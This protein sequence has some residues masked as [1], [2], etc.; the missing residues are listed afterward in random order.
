MKAIKKRTI[1]LSDPG[2]VEFIGQQYL[3]KP[4]LQMFTYNKDSYAED[5][6]FSIDKYRGEMPAGQVSWMNVHGIHDTAL[7][8]KVCGIAGIP[9]FIVQDIL[10]TN[11]RPKFQDLDDYVFITVKS[12]LPSSDQNLEIEQISFLLGR[13]MLISFQEK[14]GDHFEHVRTRI[15]EGNGLVREKGPDFLLFLL[16]EG[17]LANYYTTLDQLEATI[18]DSINPLE[19]SRTDPIVI[20]RIESY[21]R[22]LQLVRRNLMALRDAMQTIDKGTSPLIKPDQKK[23]YFDLKDNC[24]QLIES[25][26][27]IAMRLDSAENLFFS[28]QGHRM[29]QVMTV[30]TIMAAIFI[31]LTFLAGIYGMNF[32]YMPELGWRWGYF[33]LLGIMLIIGLVF[34]IYFRRKKWL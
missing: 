30:L 22:K 28:L 31:P 26:D 10:D 9:R 23:Y 34:I 11:Q 33:F 18:S 19:E 3:D 4:E 14:K 7:V 24:L 21:K 20:E 1:R 5:K 8:R 17:I 27:V 15:R 6:H 13:Q 25:A 29:N 32:E 16:L 2:Q 12:F